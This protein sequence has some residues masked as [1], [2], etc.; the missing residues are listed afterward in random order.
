MNTW[1]Q[2]VV[3]DNST[4]E[5]ET[6]T[7]SDLLISRPW[8]EFL[9]LSPF[10]K[11]KLLTLLNNIKKLRQTTVIFPPT[12]RIMYWSYLCEPQDVKVVIIGQDPYHGGQATGL[13]FSVH[14]DKPVP[15]SL[16]NI[17]LELART[18]SSFNIPKHGCLDKWTQGGVLLLNTIL[19][20]EKGKANSHSDLGWVWFTNYIIT[21]LSTNLKNCVFMLWG[22]KAI[23]KAGL[24][25]NQQ[26]LILKAQ[27]P[28]P[29]AARGTRP[30]LWPPFS[31]CD[32]FRLANKYLTEHDKEPID[33]SV[34]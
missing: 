20:V 10:M 19:T 3:W 26:H 9:Q 23:S 17:Y 16:R 8:L 5:Q 21:S 27:H 14:I 31:G 30:S 34:E 12:D 1:L 25:N 32:H 6:V 18:H 33:W 7:D 15:P 11:Q 28:S 24:I 4:V 13:A 29:L 2:K 22:S